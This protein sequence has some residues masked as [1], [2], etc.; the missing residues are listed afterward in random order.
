MS[1][2]TSHRGLYLITQEDADGAR[3]LARTQALLEAGVVT[4]LQY[5][6]RAADA[7]AQREQA[8]TLQ[9]LCAQHGVPLII[10]DDIA[11]A[12]SIGAAGVHLEDNSIGLEAARA[13]LGPQALIGASC[14]DQAA[15]AA[16]AV[17]Q[18]ASYVSFGAFF[19]SRSKPTTHRATPAVLL[20]TATLGVPR[21]A[22][23]GLTPANARPAIDA[24]A[25]LIAAI[26]GVYDAADPIAT[27]RAFKALFD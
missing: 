14:Y 4:W 26:G 17:A 22:I 21:V 15:L 27:A 9:A 11:L 20:E 13:A 24:G 23:G 19:P 12:L 2:L 3:L 18:G 7:A 16:Q 5:R 6:N 25:D 10:N 1:R 8:T